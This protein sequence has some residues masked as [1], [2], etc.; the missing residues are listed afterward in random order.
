MPNA[1]IAGIL[2]FLVH[3][4]L[5]VPGENLLKTLYVQCKSSSQFYVFF[6]LSFA[7]TKTKINKIKLILNK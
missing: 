2:L 5:S 1:S 6:S 3:G 4:Q 7:I